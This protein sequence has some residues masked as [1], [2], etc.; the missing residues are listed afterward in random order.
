MTKSPSGLFQV[1]EH[2]RP[3]VNIKDK[4]GSWLDVRGD[5]RQDCLLSLTIGF[6]HGDDTSYRR[7]II[8]LGT[9][10]L[11]IGITADC[12]KLNM[13]ILVDDANNMYRSSST[14]GKGLDSLTEEVL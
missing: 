8:G 3:G 11:R 5:L 6:V 2:S 14:K 9:W 12:E 1:Y 7:I 10:T 13:K 4:V